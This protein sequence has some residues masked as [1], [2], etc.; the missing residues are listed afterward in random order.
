MASTHLRPE[1][2]TVLF[3]CLADATLEV[4]DME[5]STFDR[6]LNMRMREYAQRASAPNIGESARI[7][8]RWDNLLDNLAYACDENDLFEWDGDVKPLPAIS[9]TT[10][11]MLVVVHGEV[12]VPA[13][14][15]FLI[16]WDEI[17]RL[18]PDLSDV[19]R[20]LWEQA[21][22]RWTKGVDKAASQLR[23]ER[24]KA[25]GEGVEY[26]PRRVFVVILGVVLALAVAI[27][28]FARLT[29]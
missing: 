26:R 10:R 24:G 8:S 18:T 2:R 11:L 21:Q 19:N 6:V 9:A 28:V 29:S 25:R 22:R 17:L 1:A 15:R 13:E 12:L 27:A 7:Q 14:G 4:L 23:Q 20:D 3:N 5:K 16:I